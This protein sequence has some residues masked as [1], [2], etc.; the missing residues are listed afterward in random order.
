MSFKRTLIN[1]EERL[2]A[3]V[4]DISQR[5]QVESELHKSEEKY[6]GLYDS[7]RDGIVMTDMEGNIIQCNRAFLDML[8][9]TEAEIK[10]MTYIRLTPGKWHRMEEGDRR[11]PGA[12]KGTFR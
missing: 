3:V 10:K 4:R 7:V 12:G 5:K 1:G 6:H 2:L 8:G 9:Y 11:E